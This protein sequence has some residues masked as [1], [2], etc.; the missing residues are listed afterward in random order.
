M[1]K[2]SKP[3][4]Y[5]E[6]RKAAIKNHNLPILQYMYMGSKEIPL[7]CLINK[8]PAFIVTSDFCNPG[9]MKTRF[10]ID[11]NHIRQK[12]P[13]NGQAGVSLD[14]STKAPSGIFR[15]TRFDSSDLEHAK[16]VIEFMTII[17]VC[18]EIHTYITQDS[19]KNNITLKNF[20]QDHWPWVLKSAD[21]F[22]QFCKD[23]NIKGLDYSQFIDHLSS[24]EKSPLQERLEWVDDSGFRLN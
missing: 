22:N 8:T 9:V 4:A 20:D 12:C 7:S 16:D 2:S 19:A 15:E 6:D 13:F 11:F 14:K 21:N 17:P 10:R 18:T 24:I 1:F 23:L 5:S 3:G